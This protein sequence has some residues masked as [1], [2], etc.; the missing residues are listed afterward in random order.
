MRKLATI[1]KISAI[2]P[3]DGADRIVTYQVDGWKVVGQKDQ[4]KVGDLAIYCE[5][6]SWIPTEIAPFLSRDKEPRVFNE[7]KG[8]RLKTIKLKGQI[9]QGLLLPLDILNKDIIHKSGYLFWA[10]TENEVLEDDDVSDLLGIQKWEMP[11]KLDSRGI[12]IENRQA[13]KGG[14][15]LYIPKSDQERVQNCVKHLDKYKQ[16]SWEVTEKLDGSSMTVYAKDEDEGV[17]SRNI[18]LKGPKHL[19]EDTDKKDPDDFKGTGTSWVDLNNFWKV[20]LRDDLIGKLR[21]L[22]RNLAFQ[23]ELIGPGIQGNP[24]ELNDHQFYLYNIW[25]IDNQVWLLPQ[26]RREL[27]KQLEINHVPVVHD[28]LYFDENISVDSLLKHAEGK[29]CLL[30]SAEREGFVYKANCHAESFKAIS[31]NYLFHYEK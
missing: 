26:E 29:S 18:N 7:V 15:P 21:S 13:R 17:C 20:A 2:Y 14:F 6:D 1:R 30:D 9:S 24:Y 23:G 3:I 4:Y 5:I 27:A 19:E 31:N 25:D 8:E 16:F 28:D 10:S 22:E 12:P 11:V